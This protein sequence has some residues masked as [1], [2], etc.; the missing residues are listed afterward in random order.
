MKL[1]E[2][3]KSLNQVLFIE[4]PIIGF[5]LLLIFIIILGLFNLIPYYNKHPLLT[6][7][8]SIFISGA[9]FHILCEYIGLNTWYSKE[10]CKLMGWQK[11]N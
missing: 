5:L 8:L 7:S 9:L 2:S 6:R 10:Y 1:G 4:A 11:N 3:Y